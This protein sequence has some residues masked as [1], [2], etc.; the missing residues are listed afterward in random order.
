MQSL[1]NHFLVAMPSLQEPFFKHAV[2]Y[3]CEHNDE[4]AMGLVINQPIDVTVGELLDKIDI[5]NDKNQQAAGRQVFAGGPVKTDRGFVLH[6]PKPGYASSQSLSSEIMITTSKDVLA[7]LTTEDAPEQFIIT[8]GYAGWSEGQLEQEL[9][10][11]SWLIMEADPEVIFNTPI[12]ERWHKALELM[13]IDAN[14]LS[15]EAGHA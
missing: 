5:D 13:G 2:A 4:G 11:N 10:E 15:L 8:L 6:T 1:T 3:I 7:S 9:L 14:K 12:N